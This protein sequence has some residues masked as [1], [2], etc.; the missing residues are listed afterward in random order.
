MCTS[1]AV[2]TAMLACRQRS[3]SFD[4]LGESEP[5]AMLAPRRQSSPWRPWTE[6]PCPHIIEAAGAQ[7]MLQ[8]LALV[9]LRVR[10]DDGLVRL[11]PAD[12]AA[13]I[14]WEAEKYRRSLARTLS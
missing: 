7:A 1:R 9:A 4:Q 8:C 14:D 2:S 12:V 5:S 11:D 6:L 10:E 13:L 3:K